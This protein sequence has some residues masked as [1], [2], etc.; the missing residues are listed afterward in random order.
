MNVVPL[1]A[2][3]LYMKVNKST[4]GNGVEDLVFEFYLK[5][6]AAC[7]HTSEAAACAAEDKASDESADLMGPSKN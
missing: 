3:G 6:R 4:A 7:S 2:L 5:C 1:S